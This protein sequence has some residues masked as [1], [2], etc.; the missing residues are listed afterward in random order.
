LKQLFVLVFLAA[1]AF[2]L[3]AELF[4]ERH[5]ILFIYVALVFGAYLWADRRAEKRNY[6]NKYQDYRALAEGMRVQFFWGLAQLEASVDDHYLRKQRSEL[7]WICS[8]IRV[9]N[10]PTVANQQ[11]DVSQVSEGEKLGHVLKYWIQNQ[12]RYFT[13]AARREN[14]RLEKFEPYIRWL[15]RFGLLVALLMA[16]VLLVPHPWHE[17][18]HQLLSRHMI[19]GVLLTLVSLLP[20]A[21]ALLHAFSEKSALSEHSKRYSRMSVLFANAQNRVSAMLSKSEFGQARNLIEE[22]G[23]EAL[24]ENGD[25]VILH[26]ERPLEVPHAG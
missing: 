20:I 25:W 2:D 3:Y 5:W 7:D 14:H 23:R 11:K 21:A 4:H 15:L 19:R 24:A 22:L 17:E 13:E 6:Q 9:W 12:S 18:L 10:L 1:I 16:L 26:R 8:A